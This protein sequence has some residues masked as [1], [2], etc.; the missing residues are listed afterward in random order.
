MR[1]QPRGR[2]LQRRSALTTPCQARRTSPQPCTSAAAR[3]RR[4]QAPGTPRAHAGSACASLLAHAARH[5]GVCGGPGGRADAAAAAGAACGLA[6]CVPTRRRRLVAARRALVAPQRR[7][8]RRSRAALALPTAVARRAL[9]PP[10][11]AAADDKT[12]RVMLAGG[13]A[14]CISKTI[15][16]PL[17]RLTILY[18]VRRAAPCGHAPRFTH[19]LLSR[20][21]PRR[22]SPAA[23]RC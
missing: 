20:P 22:L 15:T 23:A 1:Q 6:G 11:A 10:P 8:V 18:Q 21:P 5:D 4:K 9:T 7:L 19:A 14:G 12:L 3:H 13:F 2:P 17:A 16:A